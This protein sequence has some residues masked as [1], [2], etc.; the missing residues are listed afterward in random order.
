MPL[1]MRAVWLILFILFI[2]AEIATAGPLISI[3]F[4]FGALAAMLAAGA[5]LSLFPQLIVFVV[6]SIAL[7]IMTKPLVKKYV[8]NKSVKTNADRILDL[9]G[10]VTEEINNLKGL[11]SIKVDGKEWSA[12]NAEGEEVIPAGTEVVIVEIQGVKAIVKKDV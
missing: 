11:G 10:I 9:K 2:I 7:L 12:R 4:C 3:W 5:G 1:E 8:N 6:V